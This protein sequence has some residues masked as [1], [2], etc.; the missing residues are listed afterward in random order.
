MSWKESE[1][2]TYS[3]LLIANHARYKPY[4]GVGYGQSGHLATGEHIVAY[5]N[6]PGD[7]VFAYAVVNAFVVAAQDYYVVEK[8]QRIGHG[9]IECL[10]IG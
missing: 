10:A 1:R 5:G 6:L 9:L 2:S 3:A 7:E 8:R 4:D